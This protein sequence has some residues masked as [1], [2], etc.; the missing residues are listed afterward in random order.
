[1]QKD[2]ERY[3]R[4]TL[5]PSA[6]TEGVMWLCETMLQGKTLLSVTPVLKYSDVNFPVK[7]LADAS[8]NGER[9]VCLHKEKAVNRVQSSTMP[10]TN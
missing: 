6:Q 1:M 5:F 9:A 3:L 7:L 10:S 2:S 8:K 4:G